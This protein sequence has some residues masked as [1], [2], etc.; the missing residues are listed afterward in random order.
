MP[1]LVNKVIT[2]ELPIDDYITHFYTTLDDVNKSVDALHSGSCLRAVVEIS[3][4]PVRHRYP[5]KVLSSRL[6]F[7]GVLKT[8]EHWSDI[9][10]CNMMFNIYLPEV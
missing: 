10:K 7:G 4:P 2:G 9:N 6:C 5:V 8:V 1:K 3:D